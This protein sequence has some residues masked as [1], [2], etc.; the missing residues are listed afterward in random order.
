MADFDL[1]R[2]QSLAPEQDQLPIAYSHRPMV[3]QHQLS[4]CKL[5]KPLLATISS[6][7]HHICTGKQRI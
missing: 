7:S 5:T 3:N 2:M 1:P 4:L 6:V